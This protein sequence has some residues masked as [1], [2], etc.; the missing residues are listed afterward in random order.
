[1]TTSKFSGEAGHRGAGEHT[2]DSQGRRSPRLR[3]KDRPNGPPLLL[4]TDPDNPGRLVA[5]PN[6]RWVRLGTRLFASSLDR[7][8]AHGRSPETH[9][10]RAARAHALVSRAMRLEL[11]ADLTN[12]LTKA[13]RAS[14]VRDPRAPLNRD[15][16]AEC[17]LEIEHTCSALLAPRPI[18]ARG[19]AMIS[20]LLSDGTGPLYNC[21]CSADLAGALNEALA[22]LDSTA[23]L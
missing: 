7:Q 6:R 23:S 2:H 13:R 3:Q 12:V 1:M 16:I 10:F 20:W 19:A 8:L 9:R 15:C 14:A 5:S 17:G 21:R 18:S 11:A 4:L 22:A